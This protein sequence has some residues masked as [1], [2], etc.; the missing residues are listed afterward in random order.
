MRDTGA[1]RM[2]VWIS[3]AIA[4]I[5]CGTGLSYLPG[6]AL[7]RAFMM[8]GYIFCLV[9]V[10]VLSKSIRDTHKAELSGGVETPMWRFVAWGGFITAMGL[11]AWGL[12]NMAI[13]DTYRAFLGVSWL[14]L[15]TSAFT[16]SKT[17]RDGHEADL[18]QAQLDAEDRTVQRTQASSRPAV[19]P[20][21]NNA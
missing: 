21:A 15:V 13:N 19:A 12:S 9:M 18:M 2:Q 11:T 10:L 4:I 5:L 20:V 7:E 14:Y 16:L 17:L 6:E 8:M 3:F 1:W